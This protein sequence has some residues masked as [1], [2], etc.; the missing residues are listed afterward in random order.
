MALLPSVPLQ[1]SGATVDADSDSSAELPVLS[2]LLSSSDLAVELERRGKVC[3]P[4]EAE[5]L[6][7]IEK[8][9]SFGHFGREAVFRRLFNDGFWWPSMRSQIQAHLRSCDPCTRY[10]VVRSGFHPARF[11]TAAG[12]LHHVQVDTSVHLPESP[13]GFTALLVCIDVFSGFLI[14]RA[15]KDTSAATVA[16]HLWDIF[17]ILGFPKILQSDN[18]SEYVNDILRALVTITGMEHRFIAPYNPRADGKVE[19]SIR[20]VTMIIKKMLHGTSNH[21]PLFVSFAQLTFNS[22]ISSLT[23]SSPFSLMFAREPNPLCDHS[24][25]SPETMSPDDWKA[26]QLKVISV[27]YPAISDRIHSRKLRQAQH[28]DRHRRL[29]TP[30]AFPAGSTV[31]IKDPTRQNKFEPVY[32]GPYTVVRRTRGGTYVLKD[33]TGDPLDRSVP[34]DQMKLI[35]RSRRRIDDERP[36][37]EV[38]EILD[39][40]GTPDAYEYLVH[41]K[42]YD[43]P[44]D[45]TWEPA[46]SFLDDSIVRSYW[47]GQRT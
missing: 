1:I 42:G 9:H 3:P 2:P 24:G 33:A 45:Q 13:E 38:E 17:S 28:T 39:H 43:N 36:I 5:R 11:I 12:P 37:Y 34:A 35:S 21:W 15:M 6:A 32:I 27:I 30:R 16:Q 25:E 22:K 4:S 18:G 46:T 26:Y 44:S 23:S 31:M 7:L 40:R 47:I 14:L 29:I 20:T 41:W 19:R 10:V 8:V